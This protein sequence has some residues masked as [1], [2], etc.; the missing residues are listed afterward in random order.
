MI[1]KAT[2]PRDKCCSEY[3]SP[4]TLRELHA[5]GVLPAL[6]Q[7]GWTALEGTA[8][9]AAHGARLHGRFGDAGGHPFRTTGM[10]LP[11][12]ALDHVL[13]Q[14]ATASGTTLLQGTRL[15]A[16]RTLA[17]GTTAATLQGTDGERSIVARVMV[18]AD[19]LG[20]RVARLAGLRRHGRLRR[21]AFV[22][23][24]A[25]VRDMRA[26]AELHVTR[27]AYVGLNPIDAARTNVAVVV[28]AHEARTARGDATRFFH[29]QLARFPSV[30][31]RVATGTLVRE[32]MVTGPFD[33]R[34]RR[35][36]TDGVAL[37][38]DAAEF[39]D[40]FTGE[41]IWAALAGARMLSDCLDP[42]LRAPDP[43][44][45]RSLAPYRRARR[46]RFL[47]KW[48]VERTIGHA[49]RWPWLFNHAV[50]R[51]QRAGLASMMIGVTGDFVPAS[52]LLAPGILWR[53]C[54]A[55]G[56]R[57]AVRSSSPSSRVTRRASRAA[58]L[59]PDDS[60]G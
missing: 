22:A 44:T 12:H 4:E 11:R 10:A 36:T 13:V 57:R 14:A 26:H 6:E 2:F 3:A 7:H 35:S 9:H 30:A 15:I 48:M 29:E 53:L 31:A 5:L 51:I 21:I 24:V 28:R 58:H 49:M 59:S 50:A 37:V 25:G 16:M 56:E 8:V 40:P 20:S 39:F 55:N 23:H 34:S 45:H 46:R 47:G 18:G 27:G 19:G 54:R 32:V 33:A 38:G 60:H 1:D 17:N 52:R 43:I 42:L 41:G